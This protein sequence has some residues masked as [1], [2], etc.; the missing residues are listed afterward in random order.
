MRQKAIDF[1]VKVEHLRAAQKRYFKTRNKDDLVESKKLET[2]I[3][4]DG[5]KLLQLLTAKKPD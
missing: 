5:P 4:I 3:D 2:E 1:V